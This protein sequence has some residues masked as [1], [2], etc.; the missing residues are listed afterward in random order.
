MEE[1]KY[2]NI[3][4]IDTSI[5]TKCLEDENGELGNLDNIIHP[6]SIK[7][8]KDISINKITCGGWRSHEQIMNCLT[9]YE[10][11]EDLYNYLNLKFD[12]EC[13]NCDDWERCTAF[14]K[15]CKKIE[16]KC[17]FLTV[18]LEGN[19]S[20]SE[21]LEFVEKINEYLQNAKLFEYQTVWNYEFK[22]KINEMYEGVHT[23]IVFMYN[24]NKYKN[25]SNC[26]REIQKLL[27]LNKKQMNA[28]N[29]KTYKKFVFND[30]LLYMGGQTEDNQK[31]IQ[32]KG[33]KSI[34]KELGINHW[35]TSKDI[36]VFD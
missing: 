12:W 6:M 4:M 35:Y 30:K 36:C 15:K 23:H 3:N 33:D 27:N 8:D 17:G 22:G 26:R 2:E 7:Y 24:K 32:K 25:M 28:V 29:I 31:N 13:A 18:R 11:N 19:K 34:R 14:L 16:K 21:V 20:R 10:L 9:N 5:M 1:I